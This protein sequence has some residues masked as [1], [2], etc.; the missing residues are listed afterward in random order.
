MTQDQFIERCKK[1]FREDRDRLF[2]I[3]DA[4]RVQSKYKDNISE[5]D[6]IC[7]IWRNKPEDSEFPKFDHPLPLPEY[8]PNPHFVSSWKRNDYKNYPEV[9]P[10]NSKH[11]LKFK[12]K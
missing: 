2:R 3:T 7:E 9:E 5:I 12:L 4:M 6:E 11:I 8:F 10:L 1:A